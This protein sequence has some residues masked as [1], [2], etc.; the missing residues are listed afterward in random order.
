M[1]GIYGLIVAIGLGAA[2][3]I[4]NWAYLASQA[5]HEETIAIIGIKKDKTINCGQVLREDDIVKLEI[6]KRA[7]GSL[8]DYAVLYS[9]KAGAVGRAVGRPLT[10]PCLLLH[11]DL[12][13]PRGR[14]ELEEGET[15]QSVPVDTRTFVP[16]LLMPGDI[17]SFRV[18]RPTV[19]TLATAGVPARARAAEGD[20]DSDSNPPIGPFKVLAIGNRLGNPDVMRAAKV[21]QLQESVLT[22]RVS[23]RVAGEE[24]N[25]KRLW[26]LLQA[27]NFRQVGIEIHY[28]KPNQ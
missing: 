18:S 13:R 16:S 11:E 10:G 23:K 20:D 27:T 14:L 26:A 22:I 9:A 25:F 19:P 28:R 5:S 2:G 21:P 12:D 1:K 7:I 8:R 4:L 17:V 6:P 3:A 15:A 24:E